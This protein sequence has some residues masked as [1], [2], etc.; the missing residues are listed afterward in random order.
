[1]NFKRYIKNSYLLRCKLDR[2]ISCLMSRKILKKKITKAFHVNIVKTYFK[3]GVLVL[4]AQHGLSLEESGI[5]D[6]L[7]IL[8]AHCLEQSF[9]LRNP[10]FS[11]KP[12]YLCTC[13]WQHVCQY[14][15][16]VYLTI[17]KVLP[18]SDTVLG[19]RDTVEKNRLKK[20]T[21]LPM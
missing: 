18:I 13:V 1:M 5:E 6:E 10:R 7:S 20:K 12:T 16:L 17:F 14:V 4:V 15:L 9:L 8:F 2:Y 21:T 3:R 11:N 19:T